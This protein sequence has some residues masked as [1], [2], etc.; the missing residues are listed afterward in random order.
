MVGVYDSGVGGLSVWKELLAL[1]PWQ[2]YV[3]VADSA[4]CPYGEKS[5]GFIA[6]RA[7]AVARFLIDSGAD[8]VVVACNTAT[9]AAISCLR[10]AFPVPFVGMEPAVKPAVELSRTGVVGV[11]ATANT[12]RGRLYRDTVVRFASDIKV[13]EVVGRGLVEA[14]EKGE[15]PSGL[16]RSYVDGMTSQ[17]AD[18]IVLGCTHFPFLEKEI[19]VAA[20]PDVRILNPAPAVARQTQRVLDRISAAHRVHVPPS[21]VFYSTGDVSVL[22]RL[23]METDPSLA[24]DAFKTINI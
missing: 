20:G 22:R 1:M 2:D 17:G 23:A 9:A 11:L 19:S 18:V 21:S 5:P 13:V 4:N 15:T 12:F 16:I 7:A 24:Q 3:Y 6:G 14:V 10:Q 8:V